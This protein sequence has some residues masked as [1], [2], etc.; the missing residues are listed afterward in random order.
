MID[1]RHMTCPSF[2]FIAKYRI[3]MGACLFWGICADGCACIYAS[4]CC[5]GS[6]FNGMMHVFMII[7]LSLFCTPTDSIVG[8]FCVFILSKMDVKYNQ[9]FWHICM[10]LL[11]TCI[12][13][14]H[15]ILYFIFDKVNFNFGIYNV[16][17]RLIKIT[18]SRRPKHWCW[19]GWMIDTKRKWL[20][21]NLIWFEINECVVC[22]SVKVCV[23]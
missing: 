3:S 17:F 10:V 20:D 9:I 18:F 19:F 23:R 8:P 21:I 11:H 4:V 13:I 5:Y 14:V 22:I 7:K 6:I 1:S 15:E 2:Q 12:H 16:R